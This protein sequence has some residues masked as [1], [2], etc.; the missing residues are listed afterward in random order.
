M[1][2]GP[3]MQKILLSTVSLTKSVLYALSTIYMMFN[4][5]KTEYQVTDEAT[6]MK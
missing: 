5:K 1:K 4:K 2:L 6:E 3:T